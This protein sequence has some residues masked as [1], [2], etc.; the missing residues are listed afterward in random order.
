MAYKIIKY[1]GKHK[2]KDTKTGKSV[3]IDIEEYMHGGKKN[4]VSKYA[5]GGDDCN[6]D[7]DCIEEQKRKNYHPINTDYFNPKIDYNTSGP[8]GL[9]NKTVPTNNLTPMSVNMEEERLLSEQLDLEQEESVMNSEQGFYDKLERQN[10]KQNRF[11]D[12]SFKNTLNDSRV[13]FDDNI[14]YELGEGIYGEERDYNIPNPYAGVDIPSAANYLGQSIKNKNTLGIVTGG[15][16]VAAGLG[17]NIVSGLGQA[18]RYN[19][20]MQDYYKDQKNKKNPVQYLAYGGKRDEELATGEFMHG[21]SNEDIEA[22]NAE[23]EKGEYFQTNEGDIAEVVG[24]TH[25]KGG[26]KIKMEAE[27]RVLSDKLK[28]GAKSAKILSEKYDLKL[29]AKNTYSDVLDKFRKKSK[30]GKL[31]EEEAELLKKVGEQDKVSDKVTRDFN[32]E[33]L[34]KKQEE[35]KEKKHPIEE[36]RKIMF[37]ELFNIQEDSKP[38]EKKTNLEFGGKLEDLAKEFNIPLDRAKE[39][40]QNFSNGGKIVPKYANGEEECPEGYNKNAKGECEI[41]DKEEAEALKEVRVGQSRKDKFY[42]EVTPDSFKK[43]IDRNKWYFDQHPDFDPTD[44]KQVEDF[45]TEYNKI[46]ERLGQN[47][48]TVDGK[49][50]EQTDSIDVRKFY[51]TAPIK[52]EDLVIE[53]ESISRERGQNLAG[54]YLFPDESPLPPSSLQGTIKP[55]R[56]FD[57]VTPS[58]IEVEP[59][60]QDIRDREQSQ[61]QSLEGLSPNVRAAVLAN[62]RANSQKQESN[63]RNQID[64]QNLG[65]KERAIYTNAQIQGREENASEIDRLRFEQ[66]QYRAQALTDNDTSNYYDQLQS[67]NKQ[68]FMD[69]HNLNLINATNE[70][71]YYDGQTYRRK[72]S[73]RDILRQIKV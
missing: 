57:R 6:G 58:E 40:V 7:P 50:G 56:R 2:I 11:S 29:K 71:V 13:E 35:I 30:L 60:L 34:A 25:A 42:G 37:D 62:M 47:V 45:Q 55:E 39:L 27:D 51:K 9:A 70:D 24:D 19:Q 43:S 5:L 26:E 65:S 46:A 64:T 3:E 17:R 59:Y 73:D 15:L 31:V 69:V 38:K 16:K 22:F 8:V 32:L 21:I 41:L 14:D 20:V 36:E 4:T 61:V 54:M 33:I 53:E 52:E 48:V 49:W 1:G 10:R 44:E 67:I 66:R 12:K 23:I 72:N 28:L 18:N 63:I 68:K